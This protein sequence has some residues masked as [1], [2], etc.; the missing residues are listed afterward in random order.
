MNTP[1]RFSSTLSPVYFTFIVSLVLST[2]A[3]STNIINSDGLIYVETARVFMDDGLSEA[4]KAFSWPFFSILMGLLAK[5]TG[6]SPEWCGYVLNIVFMSGACALLVSI[7]Q[8]NDDRLAWLA[9]I[10]VLSIPGLNDYRSL[11][12][13]EYGCWFFMLLSLRLSLDWPEKP[14]WSRCLAIQATLLLAAL[15]RPEALA[16]YPC[17]IFWQHFQTTPEQRW[18]ASLMLGML[19]ALAFSALLGAYFSGFLGESSRLTGEFDR[20]NLYAE[21]DATARNMG[22][23]FNDYARESAKTAHTILFFGSLSIIPW[24]YLGA[25]GPFVVPILFFLSAPGKRQRYQRHSLLFWAMCTHLLIL[26]VFVLRMQFV[27][28]RYILPLI[29]FSLPF[30]LYGLQDLL[31]RFPRLQWPILTL[32]ALLALAN[33]ISLNSGKRHYQE[34]GQW[35]GEQYVEAPRIYLENTRIAYYAGWKF[36]A[37]PRHWQ[38]DDLLGHIGQYDLLIFDFSHKESRE[39]A[40]WPVKAGLREVRRFVDGNGDAVIIYVPE[41][42]S[43]PPAT[44][45]GK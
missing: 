39:I 34:A 27:A 30:L 24:K 41:G 15:F 8:R 25:L 37:R 29:L 9:A 28:G 2:I 33:V 23:A 6:L 20:F 35:L 16:F 31:R 14:C 4:F 40:A 11:L 17:I 1:R 26:A 43:L 22:Q 44:A 7:I 45:P 5:L 12:I 18:R 32:C 3:V 10:V 13:R 19:P 36:K 21:F 42:H 38:R